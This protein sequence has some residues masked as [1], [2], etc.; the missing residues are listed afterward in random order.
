MLLFYFTP[1]ELEG[2]GY[3]FLH[4]SFGEY[5]TAQGIFDAF[6]RWGAPAI[7]DEDEFTVD[8]FLEK[9][10]ALTSAAPIT[11]EVIEFL[12]DEVRLLAQTSHSPGFERAR[13]WTSIAASLLDS[14]I[15]VGFPAHRQAETWRSAER[16][17]RNAEEALLAVLSCSA[18]AAYPASLFKAG[19]DRGGWTSGPVQIS[20]FQ[21][22][23][24]SFSELV[25]RLRVGNRYDIMELFTRLDLN[26]LSIPT[27]SVFQT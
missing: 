6:I 23:P 8:M 25:N 15:K 5:L 17:Q 18:R 24:N 16:A 19:T 11:R 27:P 21:K 4:K 9:W 3:E 26:D 10:L 13:A 1:A 22:L 14:T 2:A 20:N 12:N 7:S